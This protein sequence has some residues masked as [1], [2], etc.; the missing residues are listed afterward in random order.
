MSQQVGGSDPGASIFGNRHMSETSKSSPRS[1]VAD[2]GFKTPSIR[3][4]SDMLPSPKIPNRQHIGRPASRYHKGWSSER[5]PLPNARR[6]FGNSAALLPLGNG[7]KTLPSK[8]EDAEKWICSPI[9]GVK[10]SALT[11]HHRRPKSKSGPLGPSRGFY[12]TGVS[13]SLPD[14]DG[15]RIPNF[16]VNSPFMSGILIAD[17]GCCANDD[18]REGGGVCGGNRSNSVQADHETI[19][20]SP[21]N[22]LFFFR[23]FQFFQCLHPFNHMV[24]GY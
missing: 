5:V 21:S 16:M 20:F 3:N 1:L 24:S 15:G 23:L 2:G 6:K 7:A 19:F 12:S 22:Y 10:K 14:F 4:R 11:P 17:L 9:D 18:G 13:P 8:W